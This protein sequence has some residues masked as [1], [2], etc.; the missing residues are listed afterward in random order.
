LLKEEFEKYKIKMNQTLKQSK[1][2]KLAT[3]DSAQTQKFKDEIELLKEKILVI[4]KSQVTSTLDY[5]RQIKDNEEAIKELKDKHKYEINGLEQHYKQIVDDLTNEL[6]KKRERT[7][8]LITD[9]DAEIERLSRTS[10]LSK[11]NIIE[12]SQ[13]QDLSKLNLNTNEPTLLHYSQEIAFKDGEISKLRNKKK[14]LEIQIKDLM[15]ENNI[16]IENYR[17]QNEILKNEIER[18]KLNFKRDQESSSNMEYI[19]NVLY[20][21]LTTKDHNVKLSMINAI[22]QILQFSKQEKTKV[23]SINV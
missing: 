4:E 9:K 20:R 8:K 18:L 1:F 15:A 2:A 6:V 17:K 11:I 23:L 3:N 12:S 14:E 19:K 5:Q 13:Q 22:M 16:D 10:E 7:L 21:F